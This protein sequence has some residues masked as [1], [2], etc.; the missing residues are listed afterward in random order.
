MAKMKCPANCGGCSI[1]GTEYVANKKGFINVPDEFITTLTS[2]GYTLEGAT[3]AEAEQAK[4]E[5]EAGAEAKA[6]AKDVSVEDV[7]K[8]KSE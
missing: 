3:E 1:G 8:G 5:A 4:A 7:L 6:E 2:H